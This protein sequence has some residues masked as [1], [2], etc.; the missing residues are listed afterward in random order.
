MFT[1]TVIDL[2][3]FVPRLPEMAVKEALGPPLTWIVQ[4]QTNEQNGQP[5]RIPLRPFGLL[6]DSTA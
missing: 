2:A 1:G 6:F 3:S 5:E 4:P